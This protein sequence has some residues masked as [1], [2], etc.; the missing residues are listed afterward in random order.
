[1]KEFEV[2][3]E[4]NMGPFV[5]CGACFG[6]LFVFG[7][8]F[9]VFLRLEKSRKDVCWVFSAWFGLIRRAV[10]SCIWVG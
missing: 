6:L 4:F 2:V 9:G 1:M 5:F 7:L 8:W 3:Y 10:A